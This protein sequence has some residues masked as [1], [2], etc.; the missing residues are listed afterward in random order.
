MTKPRWQLG[1]EEEAAE[2]RAI[3]Q[4]R[5]AWT[6]VD[7]VADALDQVAGRLEARIRRIFEPTVMLTP[8]QYAAEHDPPIDESTVRRWC[9]RGE[10]DFEEGTRGY[11]IPAGAR[12]HPPTSPPQD[13]SADPAAG[14]A[15]EPLA[16]AS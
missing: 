9:A 15:R 5:R 13:P 4:E 3:A 6:T 2:L 16:H 12:R 14:P 1:L 7:P 11:L 8:A 10:L